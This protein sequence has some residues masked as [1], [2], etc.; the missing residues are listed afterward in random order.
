MI[1][2]AIFSR[3]VAIKG[4][5]TGYLENEIGIENDSFLSVFGKI[6]YN[7]DKKVLRMDCPEYFVNNKYQILRR[8]S[9]EI[10]DKKIITIFVLIPLLLSFIKLG[11]I[12]YRWF[13]KW[14]NLRKMRDCGQLN[15]IQKIFMSD[16]KC[17]ICYEN[18][19]NVILL[20]CKHFC[21]CKDC[22]LKMDEKR[23]PNCKDHISKIIEIFL[24]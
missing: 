11:A 7:M 16:V 2:E 15:N 9:R 1:L 4:I 23:C 21:V 13:K 14:N 5:K 18:I 8:I 10:R 6:S 12:G 17:S 24:P 20:P 22:Y 19:N 3:Q